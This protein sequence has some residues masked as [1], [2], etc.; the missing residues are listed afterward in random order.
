MKWVSWASLVLLV[1]ILATAAVTKIVWPSCGKPFCFIG[2]L[3]FLRNVVA[4]VLEVAAVVGLVIPALQRLAALGTVALA[5]SFGGYLAT[6]VALWD[7]GECGC[8]GRAVVLTKT[9]EG[10]AIALLFVT[11]VVVYLWPPSK[12]QAI[13]IPG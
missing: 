8:F 10:I 4:P 1:L 12:G 5:S 9:G 7:E 3:G 6:T 2:L 13:S 11:A